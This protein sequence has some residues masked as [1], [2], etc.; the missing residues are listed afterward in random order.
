MARLQ[1]ANMR[2]C[3]Q[4]DWHS[5]FN[6]A[7]EDSARSSATQVTALKKA[8]EDRDNEIEEKL[9]Q[10]SSIE[11]RLNSAADL[12][13]ILKDLQISN[14]VSTESSTE[15]SRLETMISRT[16]TVYTQLLSEQRVRNFRK[17]Q[18][19]FAKLDTLIKVS[20][21]ETRALSANPK[22]AFS[23]MLFNFI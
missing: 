2:L 10:I 15:L 1:T 4:L 3:Q 9:K 5:R 13:S 6:E 17:R 8:L 20:L 19:R 18:E 11:E 21:G 16:A 12:T 22:Q 7:R 23:A 14:T